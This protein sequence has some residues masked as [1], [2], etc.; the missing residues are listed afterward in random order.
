MFVIAKV[1]LLRDFCLRQN[2]G[3]ADFADVADKR[4]ILPSAKKVATDYTDKKHF[5]GICEICRNNLLLIVQ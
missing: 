2:E 1:R 3:P 4:M 5:S